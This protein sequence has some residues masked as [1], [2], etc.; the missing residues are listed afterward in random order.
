MDK[1]KLFRCMDAIDDAVLERSEKTEKSKMAIWKWGTLAACLCLLLFAAAFALMKMPE[2]PDAPT[3]SLEDDPSF[4]ETPNLCWQAQ[5]NHVE[6]VAVSDLRVVTDGYFNEELTQ[7]QLHQV[8]PYKI[9]A[10]QDLAGHGWFFGDG[11]LDKVVLE[12]T[13]ANH[14]VYI[15]L[16]NHTRDYLYDVEEP[17]LS[18][19]G[20]VEYEMYSFRGGGNTSVL[21]A[22]SQIADVSLFFSMETENLEQ[23]KW[24][25]EAVLENFSWYGPDYP[26]LEGIIPS[27]IPEFVN[28][29]LEDLAAARK[30]PDFGDYMLSDTP[31]GFQ[32]E[33]ITRFKNQNTD[34]LSGLW[35]RG[36][37]ELSWCISHCVEEDKL[38]ITSVKDTENYDLA[39]YPI[40]RADSVPESIREIVND[41]IFRIEELTQKAVDMRAY[42]V[43][44]AG[45]DGESCRMQFGVLYGDV[46]IRIRTKGVEPMWV[47]E[48][49]MELK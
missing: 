1:E 33:S 18:Y 23:G 7:K 49:L 5:Y 15:I 25:F 3:I 46:L 16:G 27:H 8:L 6:N 28:E 40:P 13:T 17:V 47:Y 2:S 39:L 12:A 35:T 38:R 36:Y 21:E 30:D 9:N 48:K 42:V 14:T 10:W 22:K 45:E 24:E 19:C 20:K 4:H 43:D 26:S 34:Q 41:P 32:K 11:K 44:D 37:D 31:Q 29:K